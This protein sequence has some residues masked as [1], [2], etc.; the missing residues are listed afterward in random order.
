MIKTLA[1]GAFDR[2]DRRGRGVALTVGGMGA[3][4]GGRKVAALGLFAKGL[5]DLEAE[6]RAVHPEFQ[7]GLRERW[8]EAVEFYEATHTDDTN[9]KLHVVGIPLIVGG[10]VGLLVWPSY[11]PPWA[12]AA[13]TFVTGW[14]LNIAGHAIFEKNA[15]AFADDP[16]SFVAGPVFDAVQLRALVGRLARRGA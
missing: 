3:L 15:P 6:W 16:L 4:L 11:S 5:R 1:R 7:G 8:R 14:G 12:L 10:A 9:R 2:L 13:G